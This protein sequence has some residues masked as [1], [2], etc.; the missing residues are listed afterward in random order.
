MLAQRFSLL[1]VVGQALRVRFSAQAE[2]LPECWGELIERL[3]ETEPAL[4]ATRVG[5]SPMGS[6]PAREAGAERR[7]DPS[8]V[9][10]QEQDP[11]DR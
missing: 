10:A 9:P 8:S 4:V 2:A 1:D 11:I 7:P 6:E 3:T 5:A